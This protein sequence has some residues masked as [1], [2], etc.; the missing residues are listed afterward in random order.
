MELHAAWQAGHH[1]Y[2]MWK[3]DE[4]YVFECFDER[5]LE[6]VY[7]GGANTALEAIREGVRAALGG[8]S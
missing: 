4:E 1:V 3:T 6:T 7:L 2:Q 8:P 5:T